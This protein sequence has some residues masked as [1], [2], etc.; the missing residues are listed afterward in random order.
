MD[1]DQSR[2]LAGTLLLARGSECGAPVLRWEKEAA[3]LW[4]IYKTAVRAYKSK[5]VAVTGICGFVSLAVDRCKLH[6]K[7]ARAANSI[8][9]TMGGD[10]AIW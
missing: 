4:R 6:M 10:L 7:E 3:E 1:R 2:T 8:T 5:S 9:I